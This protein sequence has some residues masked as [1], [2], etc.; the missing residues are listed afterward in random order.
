MRRLVEASKR[1]SVKASSPSRR[2]L[3]RSHAPTL[4]RS[5]VRLL[6]TGCLAL[7]LTACYHLGP[8]NGLRSGE[9]SVQVNPF[10][11]QTIEPRLSDTITLSLRKNLQKDGTYRLNTSNEGDIIVSGTIINYDRIQLSFQ[12]TDI[13]TPRQYRVVIAAQVTARER[14]SG[15]VILNRRVSGQS[16]LF[17]GQDLPSAERQTLPLVTDELARNITGLLVDG[18]W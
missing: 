16:T 7:A 12:P 6:C 14:L 5:N 15:K 8:T 2:T 3:P 4:P 1:Q 9:R 11:N 13:L 10:V 18:E 17:V